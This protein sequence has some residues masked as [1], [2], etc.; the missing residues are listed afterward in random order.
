M[1]G[2]SGVG[3]SGAGLSEESGEPLSASESDVSK[4]AGVILRAFHNTVPLDW[5]KMQKLAKIPLCI[6]P[7][8]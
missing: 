1:L 8:F 5:V 3:L 4:E 2:K 7:F 6:G